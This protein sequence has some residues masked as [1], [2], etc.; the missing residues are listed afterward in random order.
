MRLDVYV[1]DTL[2]GQLTPIS[3][4]GFAFTYRP[5]TDPNHFVSLTMPVRDE[6][7]IWKRGLPPIFL[8]NLPE[9]YQK[10]RLREHLAGKTEVTDQNLLAITGYRTIGR[11]RVVPSGLPLAEA[12]DPLNLAELLASPNSR[13][14]LL[15]SIATQTAVGVSGVMPKRLLDI[16]EPTQ[17]VTTFSEHYLL[18]TGPDYLPGLAI[19]EWLC[20]EVARATNFLD[21]PET[22]L[23]DDGEVVA[24]RRF[25]RTEDG[26]FIGVEDC[27]SLKGL[28]PASKY[29]GSLEDLAKYL[30]YYL[31]VNERQAESRKLMTLIYLNYALGNAD[32]HLK[33]FA[34]TY[35]SWGTVRL[36]P[37]YDIVTVR[38]YQKYAND[39]PGLTLQ[40]KKVWFA[41]KH[42]MLFGTSRLSLSPKVLVDVREAVSLAVKKLA[43]TV[44][45]Y[46]D[47][48][49]AF[50][51]VGKR[52]LTVW[53]AGLANI[54]PIANTKHVFP[55]SLREQSKLSEDQQL[56][57]E[58]N[59]YIDPAG[60]FGHKAR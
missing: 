56:P 53:D 59:P 33:N 39:L 7:Y 6:S 8:M 4:G 45:E 43:P 51:E 16:P 2:V 55:T 15:N 37:A 20:L 21:V 11:V 12:A 10:D 54:D 13:T 23:S 9:G 28:D 36:A 40:G 24:I 30:K 31:P 52:M 18:K 41:G 14:Q 19:N 32:A 34:F 27:C 50:R 48:Y 49:P 3:D 38:A 22:R 17:K 1:C 29:S 25:D 35:T 46:A 47:K 5:D 58:T 26:A 57:K 60:A 42:L 44:A